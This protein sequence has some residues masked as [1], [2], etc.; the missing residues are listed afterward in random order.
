MRCCTFLR[1]KAMVATAVLAGC[2]APTP[3]AATVADPAVPADQSEP[4]RT[5]TP[6]PT[7]QSYIPADPQPHQQTVYALTLV[8][9]TVP[10]GQISRNEEFWLRF[11]EQVVDVATSDLLMKNGFRV[12][13]A[14]LAEMRE[15]VELLEDPNARQTQI[16]HLEDRS[17]EL[18]LQQGVVQQN[19][20]W[21]DGQGELIGKTVENADLHFVVGF[22]RTPRR[23]D[24]LTVS[25]SPGYRQREY[26]LEWSRLNQRRDLEWVRDEVI[27]D[28][29]LRADLALGHCLVIAPGPDSDRANSIGGTYL[30]STEGPERVEHIL[31]VLPQAVAMDEQRVADPTK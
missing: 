7:E 27:Y 11:D 9:V 29:N 22:R 21:F 31:L 4:I 2:A 25:V 28:L 24:T 3:D 6:R 26:R 12:G 30:R 5:D 14:P 18:P 13:V 8:D 16:S 19:L 10:A 15:V 1:W 23:T 17:I 20:F